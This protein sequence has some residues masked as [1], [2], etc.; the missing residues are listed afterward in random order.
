[1]QNRILKASGSG[2]LLTTRRSTESQN[3]S[4]ARYL[5]WDVIVRSSD[6]SGAI[7]PKIS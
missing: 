5:D 3:T 1:V 2:G 7:G 6:D 4:P